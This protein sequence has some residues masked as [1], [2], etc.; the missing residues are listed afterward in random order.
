MNDPKCKQT[1]WNQE[2]ISAED[3]P[4]CYEEVDDEY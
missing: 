2:S 4:Q 3:E 1:D